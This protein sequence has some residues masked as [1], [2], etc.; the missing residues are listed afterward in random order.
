MRLTKSKGKAESHSSTGVS[1]C[2]N[3]FK[4]MW[5]YLPVIIINFIACGVLI[6]LCAYL[7]YLT[8]LFVHWVTLGESC[9]GLYRSVILSQS[10]LCPN[11]A[12]FRLLRIVDRLFPSQ[13]CDTRPYKVTETEITNTFCSIF[14]GVRCTF[15][16]CVPH[17]SMYFMTFAILMVRL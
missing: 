5:A 3:L 17:L 13:T 10:F 11:F 16:V 2:N 7:P 9:I 8:V 12:A 15:F 6:I 4:Q 14:R 1:K